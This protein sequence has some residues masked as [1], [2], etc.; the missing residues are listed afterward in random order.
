MVGIM[1]YTLDLELL[2]VQEYKTLLKQQNLLPGR[3]ILWQ[4]I[5]ENFAVFES[6]KIKTVAQLKKSLSTPAKIADIEVAS[7]IP[8]EY[9]VILKREIGSLEQKPVPLSGFPSIGPSLVAKLG[10][11][12]LKTSKEYWETKQDLS[13]ELFCLCD[14]VRIN[15]VGPVAARAFYEAGYRSVYDVAAADAAVML[16]KVSAVNEAQRYY[17]ANLGLKDMQ[18]C[19]DFAKLLRDMGV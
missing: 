9:L 19:I 17:K 6:R 11:A 3:R 16:K 12:G 5:D 8:E 7:G 1:K 14:L 10:S 13:D 18:F 15:G 2:S 4:D